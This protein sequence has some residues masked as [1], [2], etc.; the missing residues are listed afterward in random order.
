MD[1]YGI[2]SENRNPLLF[3][4]LALIWGTSYVA[5]D[6][7]LATL[8]PALF[9]ALRYDVAGAV[10]LAY[11]AATANRW[12]PR[13]RGDWQAVAVGGGLVIAVHYATLFA[14]QRYVGSGTAAVVLSTAPVLT[15]AF[16]WVLLGDR[17]GGRGVAGSLLGLVGVV[18]VASPDPAGFDP[19]TLRGVGLLFVSAASFALGA[20]LLERTDASLPLV[21]AQ[22]WAMV[23]GAGLLHLISVGLGEPQ[24]VAPTPTA[25]LAVAYLGLAGSAA[26]LLVY[27]DLQSRLGPSEVSLVNYVVPVVAAVAGWLAF[28]QSLPATTVAGFG[29]VFAGFLTLKWGAV[30]PRVVAVEARL[31]RGHAVEDEYVADAPPLSGR[32][33]TGYVADD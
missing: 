7:G 16:A 25:A 32:G 14:G 31:S 29:L 28:G 27:F 8:P 19:A 24:T 18:V 2:L 21:P 3:A 30:A 12:R 13:G 22:A 4:L 11:A 33:G 6:A 10:M 5:I 20:V 17:L 23:V 9:A 26:G 15:P 1:A